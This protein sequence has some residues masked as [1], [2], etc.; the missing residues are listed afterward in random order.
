MNKPKLTIELVPSTSWYN[1][2]RSNVS[3][4]EWDMY[5]VECYLR[6]GRKCEI[7]G[8]TGKNQGYNHDVECHEIWEYDDKKKTQTLTRLVAL[9]PTCHKVKHAGLAM[10]RGEEDIVLNQ[11]MVVNDMNIDEAQEYLSESFALWEER[12]GHKWKVDISYLDKYFKT[13]NDL[14]D[15]MKRIRE[16]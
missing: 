16:L 6:A 10:K 12:S 14:D 13:T 5:R 15:L 4:E 11:L 9:C 2:V 3:K 8:D 1:N 7:C